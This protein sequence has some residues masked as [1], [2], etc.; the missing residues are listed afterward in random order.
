MFSCMISALQLSA[1]H[2]HY[3]AVPSA[4]TVVA[5]F[6]ISAVSAYWLI[7][8]LGCDKAVEGHDDE[9]DGDHVRT[10]N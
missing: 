1:N 5:G 3:G 6:I 10:A 8:T 9:R 4:R 7:L 2:F